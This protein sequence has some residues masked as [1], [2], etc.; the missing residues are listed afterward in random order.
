MLYSCIHMATVGFKGLM[1]FIYLNLV[2]CAVLSHF[3]A[4][5]LKRPP[6]PEISIICFGVCID[7]LHRLVVLHWVTLTFDLAFRSAIC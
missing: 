2:S 6:K 4:E 7:A 5:C 1:W 3:L